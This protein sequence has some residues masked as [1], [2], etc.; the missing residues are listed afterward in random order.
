MFDCRI[1]ELNDLGEL[2]PH[3]DNLRRD[4]I[5]RYSQLIKTYQ[6]TLAALE[7]LTGKSHTPT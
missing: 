3:W 1:Q 2:S 5:T 4:V 7:K 6:Y